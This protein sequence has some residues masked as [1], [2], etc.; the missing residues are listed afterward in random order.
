MATNIIDVTAEQGMEAS[1]LSRPE[2]KQDQGAAQTAH[3]IPPVPDSPEFALLPLVDKIAYAFAGGLI[4]AMRE[5]ESHIAGETQKV[6]DNV[7]R[8]LGA[9]QAAIQELSAALS[10]ERSLG[11]AIQ[12]KCRELEATTVS[13]QETDERQESELQALRAEAAATSVSTAGRFEAAS[14]SL[15]DT[16]ARQKSEIDGLRVESRNSSDSLSGMIAE[17]A[18]TLQEADARLVADISAARSETRDSSKALSDRLEALTK[19]LMVQQDDLAALKNSV[20]GFCT[21]VDGFSERLSRQSEALRSMFAAYSQRETQLEQLVDGLTR[22]RTNPA[23]P[24]GQF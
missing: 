2:S 9:L 17:T 3:G 5:L 10:E 21:T 18:A 4:V 19:D 6:N 7:D 23:P 15:L 14:A 12:E 13:L 11:V 8:R 20:T 16:E 1:R 24:A 22:L